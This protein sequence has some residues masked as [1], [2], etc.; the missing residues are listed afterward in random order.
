MGWFVQ[1]RAAA[2]AVHFCARVV[3]AF[4]TGEILRYDRYNTLLSRTPMMN[5]N[6]P[7]VCDSGLKW[8]NCCQH[9]F[10][11]EIDGIL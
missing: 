1:N 6:D 9:T 5:G 8:K 4:E 11:K 7:C 10:Q 2:A 3:Y